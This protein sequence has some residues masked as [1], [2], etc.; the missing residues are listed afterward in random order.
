MNTLWKE[1]AVFPTVDTIQEITNATYVPIHT[2]IPGEYQFLLGSAII[3]Y[4]D[5]LYSSWGNSYRKEN[6]ENTILA[7]KKSKD[8]GMTW[9]D[10]RRISRK[11][12]GFGR[13]HGSFLEHEGKLYAFCP[14]AEYSKMD[15]YPNL[16]MEAYILTEEEKWDCLGTVLDKA[17]WPMCEPLRLKNGGY[18]MAGICTEHNEGA[19]ALCD[20]KDLTKWEMR[21]FPNPS[22]FKYWG[23]TTVLQ[24]KDRLTAM[25]RGGKGLECVLISESYDGGNTWTGLERS[26]LGIANS[27]MYTGTLANGLDYLVFNMKGKQYRDTLCIA[28]GKEA[29]ERVYRIR[30]GFDRPPVF[31]TT[32]SNQWCYPYAWEDREKGLLYVVY[33]KNK[34]DCELAILPIKSLEESERK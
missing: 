6:D 26:N 9:E 11:D 12:P 33:A 5:T 24:R 14:K 31:E 8:G 22:D 13:S 4:R 7:Q 25:V 30:H 2:A 20:G 29:F 15:L 27:K 18:L 28:V 23:E 16:T 3:K 21:I 17:F 32:T 34:E 10:Y 1:Q 19:V